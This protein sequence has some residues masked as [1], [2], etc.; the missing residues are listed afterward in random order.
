MPELLQALPQEGLEKKSI[1][2]FLDYIDEL[3][4]GVVKNGAD[5]REAFAFL[6]QYHSG[7][8]GVI[9]QNGAFAEDEDG[10]E[11]CLLFLEELSQRQVNVDDDDS[12]GEGEDTDGR[13]TEAKDDDIYSLYFKDMRDLNTGGPND[14]LL[15]APEETLLALRIAAGRLC[16]E[17]LE[18]EK[19]SAG[20][21]FDD[22]EYAMLQNIL[23]DT[24][25]AREE[26]AQKNL[27]LVIGIALH[28]KNLDRGL[29]PIALIQEG[30]VGLLR[31]VD[32]FDPRKGR[33]ST[34]GF[35]YI[36]REVG[37]ALENKGET[38][39]R[40]GHIHELDREILIM[41]RDL[42]EALERDPLVSE[43]AE[44][45]DMGDDVVKDCLFRNREILS[46]DDD[47]GGDSRPLLSRISNGRDVEEAATREDRYRGLED[48]E[49]EALILYKDGYNQTES[50]EILG[51]SSQAVGQR[52]KRAREKLR[53]YY[54]N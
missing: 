27:R 52:L 22:E 19:D 12:G 31:A 25:A 24:Q 11:S 29:D 3:E 47:S 54:L 38:I 33:F 5:T 41:F 44:A 16:Y 43:V 14:G 37:R 36:R 39:R 18:I 2:P 7:E 8:Y 26:L 6:K 9:V 40:P 1:E 21:L 42:G 34:I 32:A 35:W 50:A 49:M 48:K 17:L 13:K 46:L 51:I 20:E 45:L 4:E 30:N 53:K 10:G 15:T 23:D 28:D